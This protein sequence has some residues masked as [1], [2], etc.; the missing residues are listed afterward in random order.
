MSDYIQDPND[1]KKQVAGNLPDNAYDRVN[2]VEG[3]TLAKTPTAV[4]IGDISSTEI[5]PPFPVFELFL[6]KIQSSIMG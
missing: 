5:A 3:C 2:T 6:L 4:I 1:S